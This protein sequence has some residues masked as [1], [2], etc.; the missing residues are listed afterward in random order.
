MKITDLAFGG[1]G[2]GKLPDGRVVFV[3]YTIPG[4]EVNISNIIDKSNYSIAQLDS[5]I[6]SS[7]YRIKPKCPYY[8]NCGGCQYMHIEYKKEVEF[9]EKQLRDI[10]ER[11]GKL[12]NINIEKI[13]CD[14]DLY[15]RNSITLQKSSKGELGFYSTD[16][17]EII[18]IKECI[19][20]DKKIN[21]FLQK[22]REDIFNAKGKKVTIKTD[23]KNI[24]FLN[25][26]IILNTE[27]SGKIL[28]YDYRTFFQVNNNILVKIIDVILKEITKAEC[29]FDIYCGV[30]TYSICLQDY[31][32]KVIGIEENTASIYF[33]NKNKKDN[34]KI[35]FIE[36]KVEDVFLDV[37]KLHKKKNNLIIINPPRTG[38]NKGI[39]ELIRN[40]SDISDII[41][42]SC[43]PAV[44]A[45]DIKQLGYEPKK[46]FLFDMFPR[47]KYFEIAAY[48]KIH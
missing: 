48:G 24:S 18:P 5:I 1:N 23:G 19:I 3:P 41:Y 14:K 34:F 40:Q 4:E 28:S 38:I 45:R 12:K 22:N 46:F 26:N 43:N 44:M 7:S 27:I 21:E 20:A 25:N 10:L 8:M 29:L 36:A 15:Y 6:T 37:F 39:I 2:V 16:N 13:L 42:I 33:A 11:I 47:T 30:G 32:D 9:K 35:N 31:F 17:K